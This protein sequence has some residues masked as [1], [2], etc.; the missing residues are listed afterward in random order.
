M[1]TLL[2]T[3]MISTTVIVSAVS[4]PIAEIRADNFKNTLGNEAFFLY[5]DFR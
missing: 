4:L 2:L 1:A 5:A 3:E